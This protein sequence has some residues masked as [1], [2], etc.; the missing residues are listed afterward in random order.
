MV[1]QSYLLWRKHG[2]QNRIFMLERT[3]RVAYSIHSHSPI[4]W[5]ASDMCRACS[6]S[7]SWLVSDPALSPGLWLH[8]QDSFSFTSWHC[9]T[10]LFA[11]L[12][13]KASQV[14]ST[15]WCIIWHYLAELGFWL[16]LEFLL[17]V[18]VGLTV[19]HFIHSVNIYGAL[20]LCQAL[21]IQQW[22]W[23]SWSCLHKSCLHVGR[24][25]RKQEQIKLPNTEIS[26][27]EETNKVTVVENRK[28]TYLK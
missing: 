1:H 28:G 24:G 18:K 8:V 12:N 20:T 27:S 25:E 2:I 3:L 4:R 26:D 6:R 15:C 14:A 11:L 7:Q 10:V 9:S 5:G 22:T 16:T 19:V 23:Q 21:L 17:K 13:N